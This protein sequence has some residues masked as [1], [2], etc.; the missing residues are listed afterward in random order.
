[1]PAVSAIVAALAPK[2]SS[3]DAPAMIPVIA[4]F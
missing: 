4:V 1:L 2:F 3:A